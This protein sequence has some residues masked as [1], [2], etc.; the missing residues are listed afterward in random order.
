MYGRITYDRIIL[1]MKNKVPSVMLVENNQ[2]L[3]LLVSNLIKTYPLNL[4]NSC[5]SFEVALEA[6][7]KNTPEVVVLDLDLG[8]GPNGYELALIMRQ[9]NPELG[10]VFYSSFNDE[11]FII[12][13]NS[14]K[15]NKYVFLRKNQIIND[16]AIYEA[17][18]QALEKITD[19]SKYSNQEI[20]KYYENFN[21]REIELMNYVASGFSNKKIASLFKI[22]I[23][24]CENAISRLAK[25]LNLPQEDSTN[26][27]ILITRKYLE[28]CGKEI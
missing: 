9:I 4:I 17:I 16:D 25:K 3:L 22:E 28:F 13:R 19:N 14:Q 8:D 11:R 7:K 15:L 23:K 27:R 20:A 24:S 1:D 2:L 21:E 18:K 12:K 10:I 5:A 6:F 26:Q